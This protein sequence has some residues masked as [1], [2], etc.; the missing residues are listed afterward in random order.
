MKHPGKYE[1][2]VNVVSDQSTELVMG[3]SAVGITSFLTN[4]SS[5]SSFN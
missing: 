2:C 1:H 4:I 3:V 5:I